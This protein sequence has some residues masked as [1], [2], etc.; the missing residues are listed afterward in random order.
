MKL[1][2]QL[3]K[4][5]NSQLRYR[6][7]VTMYD[8]RNKISRVTLDHMQ[9]ELNNVLF[10]TIIEVDTKLRESPVYDQP[11]TVY[12]PKSRGAEQYRA[13]AKELLNHG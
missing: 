9:Q 10:D 1:V 12:A 2:Q 3:R 6:V 7:L 11:I 4:Q 5:T 8:R 13:L